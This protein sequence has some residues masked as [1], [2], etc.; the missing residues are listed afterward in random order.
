MV[1]AYDKAGLLDKELL[2]AVFAVAALRLDRRDTPP[3]FKSQASARPAFQHAA[4]SRPSLRPGCP[5]RVWRM[6]GAAVPATATLL[7]RPACPPAAQELCALLRAA[8]TG[9][10][11]PT[12]FLASLA[13]TV[14]QAPWLVRN[15]STSEL[16]EVSRA[17]SLLQPLMAAEQQA[18]AARQAQAQQA[19]LR[20]V[21][22]QQQMMRQAQAQLLL[23]LGLGSPTGGL[24]L[25]AFQGEPSGW[26]VVRIAAAL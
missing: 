1:A 15:F 11:C 18:A 25:L 10:A 8:H 13:R 2:E 4:R 19:A 14:Q 20:Q 24:D 22:A 17:L 16:N 9:I 21:A 6:C 3:A 5:A 12:A 23:N 26:V 7:R